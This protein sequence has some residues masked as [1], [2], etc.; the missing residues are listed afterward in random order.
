VV[1]YENKIQDAITEVE[2]KTEVPNPFI[3]LSSGVMLKVK[4]VNYMIIQA[5]INRFHYP[6]IPEVWDKD[7]SRMIRNPEHPD[8]KQRCGE[9]EGERMKAVADA[10]AAFGVDIEH[11]PDNLPLPT[12][13]EWID[14][15]ELVGIFVKRESTAA[16]QQA[17]I[18]YVAM[19]NA[20]DVARLTKEFLSVMGVSEG[21]VAEAIRENFPR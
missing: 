8:Y 2:F 13:D 15:L 17:W 3:T 12:A 21:A 9:I 18:S 4:R 16:R 14:D 10:I 19:P 1:A 11:V 5:V 20:E 7:R 6:D